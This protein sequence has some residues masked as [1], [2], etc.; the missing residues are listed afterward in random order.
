MNLSLILSEGTNAT[1]QQLILLAAVVLAGFFFMRMMR[2]ATPTDSTP[3]QYRREV[4]SAVQQNA[5]IRR[6]MEQVLIEL[7]RLSRDVNAQIDT[8]FIKLEQSITDADKRISALRILLEAAKAAGASL[9]DA[10]TAQ[11]ESDPASID[12]SS[13]ADKNAKGDSS[14]DANG[15]QASDV[16][17][18]PAERSRQIYEL[19]DQGFSPLQIAQRLDQRVGEV[20]LILNLRG[21]AGGRR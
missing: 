9:G 8:R 17:V 14:A 16:R 10:T 13:S 7:D 19:A 6:D 12:V 18:S 20:E 4:D 21:T 11:V 1:S 3:R 15:N 2:R 5:A